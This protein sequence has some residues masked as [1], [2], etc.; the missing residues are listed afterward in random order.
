MAEN[1]R[2]RAVLSGRVQGVWYR[3]F[4]QQAALGLRLS[5]WVRN[6]P[7][8]RVEAVAEGPEPI[9]RDFLGRLRE[10]PPFARV[11]GM[12]VEWG[13]ATGEFDGFRIVRYA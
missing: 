3:G 13:E 5:G 1:K 4:A 10:G 12:D 11:D 2:V 7:D 8:G 6:R 9:L